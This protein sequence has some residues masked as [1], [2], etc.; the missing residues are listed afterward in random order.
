VVH[1]RARRRAARRPALAL[2]ETSGDRLLGLVLAGAGALSGAT[3]VAAL[4]H[5]ARVRRWSLALSGGLLVLGA[6]G[7]L[8]ALTGTPAYV[9]D[10]LLLGLPPGVGGAVTGA[11]GL[12]R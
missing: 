1:H 4:V 12:R 5:G 8:V 3:G 2:T 9:E 10:A 11:L 7:A 6:V